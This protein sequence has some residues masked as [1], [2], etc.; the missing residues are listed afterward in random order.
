MEKYLTIKSLS[1]ILILIS[2]ISLIGSVIIVFIQISNNGD[3]ISIIPQL[4]SGVVVFLLF[5]SFGHTMKLLLDIRIDQIEKLKVP[6]VNLEHSE[7]KQIHNVE[8]KTTTEEL[9]TV[10]SDDILDNL[11][12]LIKKQKK[13]LFG[14]GYVEDITNILSEIITSKEK[15]YEL[16]NKYSNKFDSEITKDLKSLSSSFSTIKNYLS[17]FIKYE[18]VKPEHPHELN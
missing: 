1:G 17:V 4:I 7:S 18:I 16:I 15:G 14:K 10:F 13:K 5:L 8:N 12:D 11:N 2:W 6:L 3:F 9:S